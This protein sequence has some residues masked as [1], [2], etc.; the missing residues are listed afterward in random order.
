[1]RFAP[2]FK[3]VHTDYCSIHPKFVSLIGHHKDAVSQLLASSGPNLPASFSLSN[4][5]S[6]SFRRLDKYP[7]LLQELQR[8][9]D[10][11]DAD[12]GDTQRAGHFYRELVSHC[13]EVRRK[14]EM[15]LEVMLGNIKDW[16]DDVPSVQTFGPIILME[17]VIVMHSPEGDVHQKDRYLVLFER[18]LLL[19]SISREMTSFRFETRIP[20]RDLTLP[21]TPRA[22]QTLEIL[23]T[24]L[25]AEAG[26]AS[27]KFVFL[28]SATDQVDACITAMQDCKRKHDSVAIRYSAVRSAPAPVP[29]A[30]S[31]RNHSPGLRPKES[32]SS[33]LSSGSWTERNPPAARKSPA[34]LTSG[35]WSTHSLLPHP[36]LKLPDVDPAVAAKIKA[37]QVRPKP[38]DDMAILQVIE[39]Y[40]PPGS[41]FKKKPLS[42]ASPANAS[43]NASDGPSDLK[44]LT[45]EVRVLKKEMKQ[46]RV[47][48]ECLAD[49]LRREKEERKKLESLVSHS[50]RQMT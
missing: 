3:Q 14:K 33:S 40:C 36:V 30:D 21:R 5:L 28:L 38:A 43:S 44:S 32:E 34:S 23:V 13:L 39:A 24:K 27:G 22:N 18:D 4:S 11:S 2:D 16:P 42:N 41:T 6:F 49:A 26:S 12:R 37:K 9:T 46:M 19:L 35:Y 17:N 45:E 15:E 20:V 48:M 50:Y 8:Y 29:A 7:A 47:E 31:G 10:E 1:M 25:N